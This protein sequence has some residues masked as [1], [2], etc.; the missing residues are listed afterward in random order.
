M[1]SPGVAVAESCELP[2]EVSAG[3][4]VS[5]F[6][7]AGT[8]GVE[9]AEEDPVLVEAG[10]AEGE[11]EV[12]IF[13]LVGWARVVGDV[14]ACDGEVAMGKEDIEEAAKELL[15]GRGVGSECDGFFGSNEDAVGWTEGWGGELVEEAMIGESGG[16]LAALGCAELGED[17]EVGSVSE[18]SEDDVGTAGGAAAVEDVPG[19]EFEGVGGQDGEG[20]WR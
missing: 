14:D 19:E 4:G 13:G 11:E 5:V 16:D 3:E 9:I 7:D 17:D 1:V 12:P 2:E 15:R 8:S 18:E 10:A 20:M 6:V